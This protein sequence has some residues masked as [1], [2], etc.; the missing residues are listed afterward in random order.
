L[1]F[2]RILQ[3]IVICHPNEPKSLQALPSAGN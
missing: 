3:P 1:H 2:H